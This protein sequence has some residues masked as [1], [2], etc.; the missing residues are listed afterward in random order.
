[1][2]ER[3]GWGGATCT[4]RGLVRAPQTV[5]RRQEKGGGVEEVHSRLLNL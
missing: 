4:G 2:R 3:W 1:M 5:Y